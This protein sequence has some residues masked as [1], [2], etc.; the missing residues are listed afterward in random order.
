VFQFTDFLI[1]PRNTSAQFPAG[2]HSTLDHAGGERIYIVGAQLYF[3]RIN[4][5]PLLY[6]QLTGAFGRVRLFAVEKYLRYPSSPQVL[7][8]RVHD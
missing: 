3:V 8:Q 6:G 1:K 4:A 2:I 7:R 5:F